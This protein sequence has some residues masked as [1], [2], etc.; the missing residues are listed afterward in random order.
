M[1]KGKERPPRGKV[2]P[3]TENKSNGK[4]IKE[5]QSMP[6]ERCTW[7]T[8]QSYMFWRGFA[9]LGSSH[10]EAKSLAGARKP[11]KT[12]LLKLQAQCWAPVCTSS[13]HLGARG[14]AWGCFAAEG[15]QACHLHRPQ[16][17]RKGKVI[18]H[19]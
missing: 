1:H 7:M 15:T 10:S 17:L 12:P 6:Q 3:H 16:A 19:C 18:P 13:H 9:Q 8:G 5:I 11:P 14:W 2:F 4:V